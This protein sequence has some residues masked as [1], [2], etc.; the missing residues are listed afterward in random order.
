MKQIDHPIN[1]DRAVGARETASKG[2][3]KMRNS[4][5]KTPW[6]L[7]FAGKLKTAATAVIVGIA[8]LA[9]PGE[10]VQAQCENQVPCY[11]NT[12]FGD[13]TSKADCDRILQ[14]VLKKIKKQNNDITAAYDAAK[15]CDT[16]YNQEL[17]MNDLRHRGEL[18]RG[19]L[20][21]DEIF[22]ECMGLGGILGSGAAR[23][24]TRWTISIRGSTVA[25]GRVGSGLIGLVVGFSTYKICKELR[26]STAQSVIDAANKEKELADEMS[27]TKRDE[28]RRT[29][30][31]ERAIRKRDNWIGGRYPSGKGYLYNIGNHRRAINGANADHAK[32]LAHFT[33]GDC[34]DCG[35]TE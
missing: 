2:E 15:Y 30:N 17:E 8:L 20:T 33:Y 21:T 11:D 25:I 31:Y 13:A 34:G 12:E 24:S 10:E 27:L 28:C 4:S 16:R 14:K 19:V 22:W 3:E 1:L 18:A 35:T 29:T 7:R 5:K 9:L 23:A 32:C 6:F 26:E